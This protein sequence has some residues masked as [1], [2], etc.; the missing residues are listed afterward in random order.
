M[1]IFLSE[2]DKANMEIRPAIIKMPVS[3]SDTQELLLKQIMS[4]L[5]YSKEWIIEN[6]ALEDASFSIK[7]T[8]ST[9]FIDI[10]IQ[11][12]GPLDKIA[13]ISI[14][15]KNAES[16]ELNYAIQTMKGCVS[17]LIQKENQQA[18][19][20]IVNETASEYMKIQ[21]ESVEKGVEWIGEEIDRLSKDPI[22]YLVLA[23][24]IVS[25]VIPDITDHASLYWDKIQPLPQYI[26]GIGNAEEKL[27]LALGLELDPLETARANFMLMS[28]W[29][30]RRIAKG[31]IHWN[32]EVLQNIPEIKPHARQIISYTKRYL[33]RDSRSSDALLA[34]RLQ[35]AAYYFLNDREGMGE[36]GHSIAKLRSLFNA[37]FLE[38]EKESSQEE[39]F[40]KQ[41]K[42][43]KAL[44][45]KAKELLQSMGLKAATTKTTG[46]GG[47]D[48]IAYSDSP[49]FSG[50]Y[51]VQCKDWAGSVGESVIRDLYGV[52][53]AESANKG[54]LIT[55]GTITKSAQKFA[56]GKPLELIDGQKLNNLLQNYKPK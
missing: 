52:V 9:N 5:I 20:K 35:R 33:I 2:S 11:N 12:F 3:R 14:S 16:D 13:E 17:F 49:I 21:I 30:T 38:T 31:D 6:K 26:D 34:L 50:K 40:V 53:M 37:G 36:A 55:T 22:T 39:N 32:G 10:D 24:Q 45:E 51:V 1:S 4:L 23:M 18:M 25:E 46:D 54:I 44:E 41:R 56:E 8:G 42:D 28:L 48:I 29:L 43:G 27:N 7:R 15:S 19:E 47:I